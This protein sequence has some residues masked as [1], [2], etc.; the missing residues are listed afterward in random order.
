MSK[1]ERKRKA[2]RQKGG[3]PVRPPAAPAPSASTPS[4]EAA[5]ARAGRRGKRAAPREILP[6]RPALPPV[7]PPTAADLAVA[8]AEALARRQLAEARARAERADA[9]PPARPTLAPPVVAPAVDDDAFT[10][11]PVAVALDDDEPAPP[12]WRPPAARDRHPEAPPPSLSPCARDLPASF[13]DDEP[14]PP[15]RRQ[16][17]RGWLALLA[18]AAA[19]LTIVASRSLDGQPLALETW[20]S[21]APIGRLVADALFSE[22]EAAAATPASPAEDPP[23][24][25][26]EQDH[27]RRDG[28]VSIKGGVV[29]V[30]ETF[31]TNDGAYD[32]YL[33]FHGNTKVVKESAEVAG[34]NAIV[35]VVNLGVGS[36]PYEEAYAVPGTYEALLEQIQRAVGQRGVSAPHVR[37]VALGSWSAGYGAISTVLNVRRGTDPLDAIMV[38]DGIHCGFLEEDP[39]ALNPLQLGPFVRAAKLAAEGQILFSITHSEI[40]PPT[41]ASA[42][43]TA[44][45]LLGSVGWKPPARPEPVVQPPHVVLRSAEGAVAKKLEKRMEPFS[46]ARAGALH[47][48]AYRGNTPEHHMAHL[49]QM[50]ATVVPELAERWKSAPK[51]VAAPRT[52][53]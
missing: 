27:I 51:A 46:D 37:R 53:P 4:A 50:A 29:F 16:T 31:S 40:E 14:A 35:A 47:V 43:Q 13:W 41:Y 28:H 3:N 15:S 30:P 33:H 21:L 20:R 39:S 49:L 38:L 44:G 7:A 18:V 19:L 17:K 45:Y 8:D 12:A 42:A 34:L 2:R 24:P 48:R 36:A 11:A 6:P 52:A 32:L 25:L 9:P 5:A 23:T 22:P 10:P 1:G 26:P